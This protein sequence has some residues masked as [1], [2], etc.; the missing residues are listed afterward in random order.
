[1]NLTDLDFSQ[2]QYLNDTM[3]YGNSFSDV[4]LSDCTAW[5]DI[6]L[7]DSKIT[8]IVLPESAAVA[9]LNLNSNRIE[10]IELPLSGVIGID[11][12]GNYLNYTGTDDDFLSFIEC[13]A[14]EAIDIS[15]NIGLHLRVDANAFPQSFLTS[16]N[17]RI[18]MTAD[19]W[20]T[21]T[22]ADASLNWDYD[23]VCGCARWFGKK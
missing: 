16:S 14:L 8:S 13:D 6:N 12:A 17:S 10:K 18:F 5:T 15:D 3:L 21:R 2:K 7:H 19:Q 4:D 23:D 11:L 20:D 22:T 1:V 9:T